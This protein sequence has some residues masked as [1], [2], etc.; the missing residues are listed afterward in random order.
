MGLFS[1]AAPVATSFKLMQDVNL[2]PVD[3]PTSDAPLQAPGIKSQTLW[4]DRPTLI[5]LIRRPGCLLCRNEAFTLAGQRDLIQNELG[6]RMV[7]VVNQEFGAKDFADNF[8]KGEAYFDKDLG[9]FKAM[10]DGKVR[11]GSLLSLMFPSVLARFSEAKKSGL[12]S[13]LAGDGTMLGGLLI[14]RPGN[15]G[16]EYEYPETT[17]GDHAPLDTVLE[18]C[19]NLAAKYPK[20]A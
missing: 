20:K 13:N 4:A 12:D 9:L 16:V 11:R 3:A 17:F 18:T 1:S 14:V 2:I 5:V 19:K 6:I 10:G 8:W 7:A 15:D